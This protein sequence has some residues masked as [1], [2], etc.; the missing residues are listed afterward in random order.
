MYKTKSIYGTDFFK[1]VYPTYIYD[2][3]KPIIILMGEKARWYFKSEFILALRIFYHRY[4][5]MK[6]CR[7]LN[8]TC[9]FWIFLDICI[10]LRYPLANHKDRQKKFSINMTQNTAQKIT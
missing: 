9:N 8:F 10:L 2:V 3:F 7:L 4:V 1:K 6:M 5:F